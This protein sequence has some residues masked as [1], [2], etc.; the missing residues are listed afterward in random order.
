MSSKEMKM[1]QD[2]LS[3]ERYQEAISVLSP[4][5]SK[6]GKKA[7]A[8]AYVE[9]GISILRNRETE[10]SEKYPLAKEQFELAL[11]NDPKSKV[12]RD[13]YQMIIKVN[14]LEKSK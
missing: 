5:T 1:A 8:Q 3:N 7:L 13:L 12:A 14:E 11:D 6:N 2:Y 10:K 9:Y 4:I